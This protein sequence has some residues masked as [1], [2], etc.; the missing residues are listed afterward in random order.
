MN[1]QEIK[2]PDFDMSAG[3]SLIHSISDRHSVRAFDTQKEV[4]DTTLGLL[5][6]IFA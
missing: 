6:W 2:L 3:K 4:S 5:L 1:A